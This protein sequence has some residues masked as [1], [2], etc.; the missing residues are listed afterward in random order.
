MM[1]WCFVVSSVLLPQKQFQQPYVHK[2]RC[3]LHIPTTPGIETP[4]Y[5]SSWHL[6]TAEARK[7]LSFSKTHKWWCIDRTT[8]FDQPFAMI[9]EFWHAKPYLCSGVN[10]ITEDP[11]LEQSNLRFQKK[12][13]VPFPWPPSGVLW[14]QFKTR[15]HFLTTLEEYWPPPRRGHPKIA[16]S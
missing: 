1:V 12:G 2:T 15:G 7:Q 14:T 16:Y 3:L 4:N 10:C 9:V 11:W 6:S 5:H 8:L 13:I